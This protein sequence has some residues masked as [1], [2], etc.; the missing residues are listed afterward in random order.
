MNQTQ[1]VELPAVVQEVDDESMPPRPIGATGSRQ[2]SRAGSFHEPTLRLSLKGPNLPN[3][4]DV[5]IPMVDDDCSVFAYLQKL[6]HMAEWG[7]K[8]EKARRIWEPT[9]TLIYEESPTEGEE[10][11]SEKDLE[12]EEEPVQEV[13]QVRKAHLEPLFIYLVSTN[14]KTIRC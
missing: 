5:T 9:Y 12:K 8:T 2:E 6:V 1:D 10:N 11:Q 13:L 4:T 7:V 14:F 3:V